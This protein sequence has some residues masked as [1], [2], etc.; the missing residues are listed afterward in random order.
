MKTKFAIGCLVQWYESEIIEFYIESLK[1]AVES[2]NGEV[3]VDIAL[4]VN[5]DLE[6]P[7]S[8]VIL[9]EQV[10]KIKSLCSFAN[11]RVV[12]SLYTIADYR[13]EFNDKYCTQ[14][15]YSFG[16]KLTC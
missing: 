8:D 5:T 6:K 12:D 2:Y 9:N 3:V 11:L 15:T 14:V 16:V 1:D 4:V 13:R 7:S 10:S